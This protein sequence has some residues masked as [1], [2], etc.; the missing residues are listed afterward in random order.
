MAMWEDY[1]DNT[2]FMGDK[3][4]VFIPFTLQI[5]IEPVRY[6]NK[7]RE[8]E[9]W[10]SKYIHNLRYALK[11]DSNFNQNG[12]V[13]EIAYTTQF[14]EMPHRINITGFYRTTYNDYK[15]TTK[16]TDDTYRMSTMVDTGD[17]TQLVQGNIGGQVSYGQDTTTA[18]DAIVAQ[19]ITN[20]TNATAGTSTE[21][22]I[23]DILKLDFGEVKYGLN[24]RTLPQ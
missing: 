7:R 4:Y 23:D 15:N 2:S 20:L 1:W 11:N 10:V 6:K 14:G 17:S 18:W 19:F 16:Q 3:T 21:I 5:V 24:Y 12:L 8:I 22:T 9:I 13:K